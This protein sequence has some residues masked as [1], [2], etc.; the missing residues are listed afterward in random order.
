VSGHKHAHSKLL[1]Y[2]HIYTTKRMNIIICP[3][4]CHSNGTDN[5]ANFSLTAILQTS[6]HIIYNVP[7]YD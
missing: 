2:C 6:D 5:N 4:L 1:S 7:R 3:T